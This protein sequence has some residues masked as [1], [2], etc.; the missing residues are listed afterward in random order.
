MK[1]LISIIILSIIG[2]TFIFSKESAISIIKNKKLGSILGYISVDISEEDYEHVVYDL[3]YQLCRHSYEQKSM[4][5]GIILSYLDRKK[6][7]WLLIGLDNDLVNM[8]LNDRELYHLVFSRGSSDIA[9]INTIKSACLQYLKIE[10]LDH[11]NREDIINKT[12][13]DLFGDDDEKDEL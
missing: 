9:Y 13:K 3:G 6:G 1:K 2:L 5:E 7:E 12:Y 8:L 11:P 10:L 4:Y